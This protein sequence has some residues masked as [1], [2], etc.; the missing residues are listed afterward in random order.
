MST[1]QL[2]ENL[3]LINSKQMKNKNNKRKINKNED[4]KNKLL[5]NNNSDNTPIKKQKQIKKSN[6]IISKDSHSIP[7]SIYIE[8]YEC[9]F[10]FLIENYFDDFYNNIT[11]ISSE[12]PN[13]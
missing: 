10:E 6:D 9:N 11:I 4:T 12:I 2:N 13:A 1:N 5:N 8:P 7:T 3:L